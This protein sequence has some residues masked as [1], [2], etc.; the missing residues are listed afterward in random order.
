MKVTHNDMAKAVAG[1]MRL[2]EIEGLSMERT[3]KRQWLIVLDRNAARTAASGGKT[4]AALAAE[5]AKSSLNSV[6]NLPRLKAQAFKVGVAGNAFDAGGTF[7][8]GVVQ[9]FNIV[10]LVNDYQNQMKNEGNEPLAR[11]ATAG[12]A[13]LGSFGEA[14]GL[15]MQRLQQAGY[16]RN[17]MGLKALR[18][19]DVLKV[20][21][22][23]LGLI[24]GLVLAG[25]DYLKFLETDAKG[26]KGLST[27]YFASALLGGGLAAAFFVSHLLG[28]IGWLI[29]GIAVIA[30]LA[31]TMWI[32]K[33]KDNKIQEW[34][35][36]CHFG[37]SPDTY[38]TE[39]EHVEQLKRAFA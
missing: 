6:E 4:G 24:T 28:P 3:D 18:V 37:T 5:L 22:R 36:R 33:N 2:M 19:A 11:L 30:L 29:V 1:Q 16:L 10:K 38:Q 13:V 15:A 9:S 25:M 31:V 8:V 32:E 20:G 35:K 7:V 39:Q 27:A 14:T 23:G 26:D 17:A 34:M 12:F 21:G